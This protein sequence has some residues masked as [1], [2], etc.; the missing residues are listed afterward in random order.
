MKEYEAAE[1]L[2]LHGLRPTPQR[3]A[4]YTYLAEHPEHPT[5]DT[6]YAA[7]RAEYPAFSRTTVYNALRALTEAGLC[8]VVLIDAEEQ[9]FDGTASDHAHARCRLC[10]RIWDLPIGD[11]ASTAETALH[12][13]LSVEQRDLFLIGVCRDC[14][15]KK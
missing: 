11:A 15:V 10:G 2:K 1:R 4:V 3:L 12:E 14:A 7:V 13:I 9:R 5:A 8:R 6:I